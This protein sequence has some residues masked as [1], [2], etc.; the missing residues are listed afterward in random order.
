MSVSR[1]DGILD[2]LRS[3]R[4]KRTYHQVSSESSDS[5]DDEMVHH[6][7]RVQIEVEEARRAYLRASRDTCIVPS[8]PVCSWAKACRALSD[9]LKRDQQQKRERMVIVSRLDHVT[10][11]QYG[12]DQ[13]NGD[14]R[15][16]EF[17]EILDSFRWQRTAAQIMFHDL[18]TNAVLRYI[19][20][21]F[22]SHRLLTHTHRQIYGV[23]WEANAVRV[24]R[25]QG[26]KKLH[27]EVMVMTPRR[28]GKTVSVAMWVVA[29]LLM[30]PGVEIGIF[31][32]GQRAS[33]S[34]MA[35]A[36]GFLQEIPGAER[37]VVKSTDKDLF[38][39]PDPLPD[40][41]SMKSSLAQKM[42]RLPTTAKLHSFP[43]NVEGG[44]LF[45]LSFDYTWIVVVFK[46]VLSRAQRRQ[47]NHRGEAADEEKR[48]V[49]CFCRPHLTGS[50]PVSRPLLKGYPEEV[51][52]HPRKEAEEARQTQSI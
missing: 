15:L 52:R 36:Y 13:C 35:M 32:T 51:Q 26:M 23:E 7:S 4:L 20:C 5:E 28:Y 40:G 49:Y 18:F 50:A 8:T 1:D 24:M 30:I 38:V 22:Y 17:N 42:A 16:K 34:L 46:R 43:S 6:M 3:H 12:T 21:L 44:Y 19:F 29:A 25:E 48:Y 10:D 9:K 41:M 27:T 2:S 11:P 37:R 31:S 33:T 14:R 39:S 47:I 45:V